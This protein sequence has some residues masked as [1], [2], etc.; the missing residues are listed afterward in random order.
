MTPDDRIQEL[1]QEMGEAFRKRNKGGEPA[2]S[3]AA[4]LQA[5]MLVDISDQLKTLVA[6]VHALRQDMANRNRP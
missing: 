6:E 3:T 2:S 1:L 4:V 5:Y